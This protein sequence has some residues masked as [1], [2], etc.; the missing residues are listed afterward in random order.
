MYFLVKLSDLTLEHVKNDTITMVQWE[1]ER[2]KRTT[3][4]T[5]IINKTKYLK[6]Q[7]ATGVKI[8]LT[9]TN[10]GMKRCVCPLRSIQHFL[11]IKFFNQ[12]YLLFKQQRKLSNVIANFNLRSLKIKEKES[13]P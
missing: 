8:I 13:F 4:K 12:N 7:N 6:T 5:I 9:E 10:E 1:R 3:R 11:L 2:E